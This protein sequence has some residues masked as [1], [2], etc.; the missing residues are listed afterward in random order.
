MTEVEKL[1][2]KLHLKTPLYFDIEE[3]LPTKHSNYSFCS[4][5]DTNRKGHLFKPENT[6]SSA[7]SIPG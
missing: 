3:N 4:W 5:K 1:N 6:S 7:L 2:I